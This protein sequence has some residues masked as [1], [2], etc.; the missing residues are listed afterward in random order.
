M[1]SAGINS[2]VTHRTL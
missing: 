1:V 2:G